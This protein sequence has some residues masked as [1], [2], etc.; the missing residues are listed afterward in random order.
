LRHRTQAG[1]MPAAADCLLRHWMIA[2]PRPSAASS[3][4]R[5]TRGRTTKSRVAGGDRIELPFGNNQLAA[6]PNCASLDR[7]A[8]ESSLQ[9]RK[10]LSQSS[11]L[12]VH[13]MALVGDLK[14][15]VWTVLLKDP[16]ALG[17]RSSSRFFV[18]SL[19]ILFSGS[20]LCL[21]PLRLSVASP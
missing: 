13:L 16:R 8:I 18:A 7:D 6:L 11:R 2:P 10:N 21:R 3:G 9:V 12:E 5:S 20:P 17:E 1:A 19:L 4:S 14:N 15:D